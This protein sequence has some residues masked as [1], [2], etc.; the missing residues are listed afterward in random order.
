MSFPLT[1]IVPVPRSPAQLIARFLNLSE[2][3]GCLTS[4]TFFCLCHVSE[5]F[6]GVSLVVLVSGKDEAACLIRP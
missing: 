1:T 5:C 3:S 4:H 6:F 2:A